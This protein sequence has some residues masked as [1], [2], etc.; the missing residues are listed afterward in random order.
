MLYVFTTILQG[1]LLSALITFAGRPWY[2]AY[3]EYVAVWGLTLLEDQQLAGALMWVPSNLLY[4][5]A[6]CLV[7]VAWLNSQEKVADVSR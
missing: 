6:V 1:S 5:L 7:F 4:I 2:P 3:E